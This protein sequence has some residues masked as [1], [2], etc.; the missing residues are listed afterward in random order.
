MQCNKWKTIFIR[1]KEKQ[2]I[3]QRDFYV[4]IYCYYS[5]NLPMKA[6]WEKV[7]LKAAKKYSGSIFACEYICFGSPV[8]QISYYSV[9]LMQTSVDSFQP[10]QTH[11]FNHLRYSARVYK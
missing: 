2:R 10:V 1:V 9:R 5:N 11:I 4:Q 7:P 3:H 8:D 6:F